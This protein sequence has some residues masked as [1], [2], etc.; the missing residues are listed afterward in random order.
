MRVEYLDWS[1]SKTFLVI[2]P[3]FML[4]YTTITLLLTFISL[5][6]QLVDVLAQISTPCDI[7]RQTKL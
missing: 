4:Y 3:V 1:Q 7:C 6:R 5:S 2:T